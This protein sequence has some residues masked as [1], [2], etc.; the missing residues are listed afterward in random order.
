MPHLSRRRFLVV[1]AGL[2][3][4]AATR[5]AFA[6]G[7]PGITRWR[8]TAL[9]SAAS[10]TLAHPDGRRVLDGA[11]AE[12]ERLEM[13]FS[14][15]RP[16]SALSR[17]N[18]DGSLVD[19]PFDLVE[20]LGL[21]GSL[22]HR[23]DGV[24]DPTIQP[25]WATFAEAFAAGRAPAHRD[26]EAAR[27]R[28]G[29]SR[30][31][32]DAGR[33]ALDDGMA[34]TLNGIAQGFIADRVAALLAADGLVD[35]MI[36]TGE[37]RALGGRPGGGDWPVTLA[38]GR[39]RVF[40]RDRALATSAPLGTTFDPSGRIGHI[41]DPRSGTPGGA[42]TQVSVSA[43]SAAVADGLSTAFSLMDRPRIDA[44]LA[45]LPDV[46]LVSAD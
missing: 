20:C 25:L 40:L 14:L 30:V 15:H 44:V 18:R 38:G 4:L 5:P 8:G 2:G 29:W 1:T 9:G 10:I 42:W 43:R 12:I 37:L 22:H 46:T 23:T 17:L 27:A 32:V 16:D 28:T 21:A 6:A 31:T 35:V 45:A 13:V 36:D 39:G 19:P 3:S 11:L 24:F 7:A 34:V 41:F 26:I 33:I